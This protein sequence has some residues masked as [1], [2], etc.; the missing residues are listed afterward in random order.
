VLGE[1]SKYNADCELH[2]P[3]NKSVEIHL[4]L[5]NHNPLEWVNQTEAQTVLDLTFHK[6]SPTPPLGWN[7]WDIFG[8][9]VTEQQ[10]K[11]QADAGK[12]LLPSG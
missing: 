2:L 12:H 3:E 9:T 6:Y 11:E 10:V 1:F 8:T 5:G 7:S 4:K